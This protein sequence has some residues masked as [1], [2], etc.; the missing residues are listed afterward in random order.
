MI[1][2]LPQSICTLSLSRLP[3]TFFNLFLEKMKPTGTSFRFH[4]RLLASL[5]L[6]VT[7]LFTSL[8]NQNPTLVMASDSPVK[9]FLPVLNKPGVVT[10]FGAWLDS[11]SPDN[12]MSP[13]AAAGMSWAHF[14]FSW[15]KVE[16]HLGD[17]RWK[18]VAW[19]EGDLLA[20]SRNHLTTILYINDTPTW[21][22]K[23]GYR[24][25]AVAQDKFEDMGRFLTDLVKRYSLP[26]FNVKY[27][28]LWSEPEVS[29]FLGCWGDPEDPDYYGGAYYGEMLKVAYPAIK[30][31]N[32]QAQVLFGGLLMDCDPDHVTQCGGDPREKLRIGRFFEGALTAG[33]GPY[34]DGVSFHAYDYYGL[35]LGKYSNPNWGA[36]WNTTGPVAIVKAAY[37]RKVLARFNVTGKYLMN[38]ELAVLCGATSH[39]LFCDSDQEATVGVYLVQAYAAGTAD[40]LR[41]MVWF[42]TGGWRGS[43]LLDSNMDPLPA[44]NAYQTARR[45]L[46]GAIFTRAITEFTNVRGYEFTN[47]GF[48]IWVLWSVTQ[49]G[50]PLSVASGQT[51][52][53]VF[54]LYGNPLPPV[55]PLNVGL[56]P[57]FVLFNL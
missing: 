33:A 29:G 20:A 52:W 30:A 12:G 38:T 24:C 3:G 32:P 11:S 41:S 56:E 35:A 26:P 15:A 48:R 17:R 1:V 27:Y 46:G 54:D 8:G 53:A 51:P 16:A 25:G 14:D 37:L 13:M 42:S 18:S 5:I 45:W 39:E 21:A 31:G 44:Y 40:G 9:V 19:I 49:V 57:I 10:A 34:F 7:T 4:T 43:E 47:N 23:A 55:D 2:G 36:A 22:L 50:N 6:V 28:E